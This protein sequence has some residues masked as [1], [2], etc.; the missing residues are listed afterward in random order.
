MIRLKIL[1]K[2]QNE[3]KLVSDERHGGKNQRMR[4]IIPQL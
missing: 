1:M 4:K 3:R 2:P